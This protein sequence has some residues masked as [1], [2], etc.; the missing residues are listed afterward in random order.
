MEVIEVI[1]VKTTSIRA[2]V[3]TPEGLSLHVAL[4]P[5]SFSIVPSQYLPKQCSGKVGQSRACVGP[6]RGLTVSVVAARHDKCRLGRFASGQWK[7]LW[8]RSHRPHRVPFHRQTHPS[9]KTS[10]DAP[11]ITPS[12]AAILSCILAQKGAVFTELKSQ[13]SKSLGV[14]HC[15]VMSRLA[16]LDGNPTILPFQHPA[17]T[18][19]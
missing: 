7:D 17:P 15:A 10:A 19:F 14:L 18:F 13:A 16:M 5:R 9:L 2:S 4:I 6:G 11:H 3:Q 8:G 12:T 1:E